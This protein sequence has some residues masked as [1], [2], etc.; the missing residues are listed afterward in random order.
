MKIKLP[1]ILGV[2]LTLVL[3][4]GLLAFA[5]PASAAALSWSAVAP[6]LT[7]TNQL[8]AANLD[9][10]AVAISPNYAN[11]NTVFAATT[12]VQGPARPLVYKSTNGGH[13]W[14][15]TSTLLGAAGDVAVDLEVSPNYA[16]DNTVFVATQTPAGGAGTGLVYRST[17]GGSAFS[18]LGVVTLGAGEVITCMSVSPSYDGIGPIA[19]GVADVAPA[20]APAVAANSVQVWGAAGILNWTGIGLAAAT[21]VVALQYS[22]NYPID[23]TLLA[24]GVVVAGQPVLHHNVGGVWD[25]AIGAV[26]V[27]AAAVTDYDALTAALA[28]NLMAAD[29]AVPS[30]YNGTTPTLRRAYVSIVGEAGYGATASNVYRISNVT[31]GIA[32][33]P[34][35]ELLDIEYSGTY[36]EGTLMGGLHTMAAAALNVYYSSTAMT[37]TPVWYPATNGPTGNSIAALIPAAGAP[38]G[39]NLLSSAHID[40]DA[41]FATS[42]MVACGTSGTDSAFAVSN[43][44]GVIWNETGLIDNAGVALAAIGDVALSPGYDTDTTMYILTNCAGGGANDTSVWRSTDNGILWTRLMARNFNVPGVG[45]IKLSAE[46]NSDG[47]MYIGDTT[48]VNVFYSADRGTTWAA[49]TIAA[50]TGVTL[51]DMVATDATTLYIADAVGGNVAK[52]SNSGWVWS[53]LTTKAT[54]STGNL[55]SIAADGSTLVVGDSTGSVFRSTDANVSWAKVGPTIVAAN[56]TF[57]DF[58]GDTVYAMLA[59][60]GD[61]YRFDIGV[62]TTWYLSDATPLLGSQIA[63]ADDGTL[64]MTDPSAVANASVRRSIDPQKGPLAPLS[65]WEWMTGTAAAAANQMSIASGSS[66]YLFVSQAGALVIYTDILSAGSTPPTLVGPMDEFE[67]TTANF[68]VI[69]IENV[70]G[71]TNWQ[72]A[73]SND[74]NFIN[75]VNVASR[76]APPATQAIINLGGLG[77]SVEAPI[78]WMARSLAGAPLTGPWSE[79]R[80]IYPQPVAGVNAPA[81]ISPAGVTADDVPINP[82]FNWGILK[83][84]TGYNLQI[85]SD[86]GFTDL[87]VDENVGHVTSYYLTT[88]LDYDS[89]YFWRV[90]GLTVSGATDWSAGVG[91]TT[92]SE[93]TPPIIIEPAP[94][95]PAAPEVIIPPAQQITPQWIYA[96]IVVGA[97]LVIVV[98]VLIVRTRRVP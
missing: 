89:A 75:N 86:A 91:F 82:V 96:I 79:S 55:I 11:D 6:P 61:I 66:N 16:T 49:R 85:A 20:V 57:V 44:A 77:I 53:T 63:L 70:P 76:Q 93:A 92:E 50:A 35:V 60:T 1:K 30:D 10:S 17:D 48:T 8:V 40:I 72:I 23:A 24:V 56:N 43:N 62:R 15:P 12:D 78:Y 21:D 26:N 47:V 45:G 46:F 59:G 5:A 94:P 90:Q 36:G 69:Q 7:T 80:V 4:A 84:A 42:Q 97:V 65:T 22:P 87:L 64:Y 29:I 9:I 34:G 2:V 73:F 67:V 31:P 32:L 14:V 98:I 74:P 81:T 28:T 95:A 71:V 41:N 33:N 83:N 39:L 52:S 37:T 19:V 38:V 3:L 54:G 18:Q 88:A 13:T 68:A 58:T 51:V 27:G 25:V